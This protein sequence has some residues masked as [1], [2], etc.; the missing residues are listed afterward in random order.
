MYTYSPTYWNTCFLTHCVIS[1]L[2][3][4]ALTSNTTFSFFKHTYSHSSML[5]QR[6]RVVRFIDIHHL[7]TLSS[8]SCTYTP[9]V[10]V[11]IYICMMKYSYIFTPDLYIHPFQSRSFWTPP[12]SPGVYIYTWSGAYTY[13]HILGIYCHSKRCLRLHIIL[14]DD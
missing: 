5:F 11:R 3:R 4:Y 14:S 8:I 12:V 9:W 10:Y 1:V 6:K 2:S 13:T 7:S